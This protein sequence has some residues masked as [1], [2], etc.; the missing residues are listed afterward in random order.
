MS[1]SNIVLTLTGPDRVGLVEE[2]T[3]ELLELGGNVEESR[4][5]RLGGEFAM[6]V[7]VSL[8]AEAIAELDNALAYL[9]EQ[10][11]SAAIKSTEPGPPEARPDWV[12]F[13]VEVE[14]ADHEGIIH[15]IARGLSQRGISI[16]SM[17]T[18]TTEAP[19]SGQPLFSMVGTVI[20]PPH[21]VDSDWELVLADAAAQ[22]NVDVAVSRP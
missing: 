2:V 16:E 12:V 9:T 17:E 3:G 10:G 4:M 19:V 20:V 22:A 8:P 18:S 7:L 1:R 5:A 13:R 11:Y 21:V 14:G 6:I 15:E